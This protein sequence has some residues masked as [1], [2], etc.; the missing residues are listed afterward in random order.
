MLIVFLAVVEGI[1]ASGG[2]LTVLRNESTEVAFALRLSVVV[3]FVVPG[4]L[5][6]AVSSSLAASKIAVPI[7]LGPTSTFTSTAAGDF[8]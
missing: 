3:P 1:A 8:M 7:V 4:V 6:T 2:W 5:A